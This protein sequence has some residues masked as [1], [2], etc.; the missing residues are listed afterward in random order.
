M[1]ALEAA[2]EK[3]RMEIYS[4]GE[5]NFAS[6]FLKK[7]Y[8][9]DAFK[10]WDIF[11]RNNANKFFKDRHYLHSE[12]GN[13]F[14]AA[15]PSATLT[16]SH[17]GGLMAADDDP[18]AKTGA[19]PTFVVLELGCGAGN[20]V[21]PLLEKAAADAEGPMLVHACDFSKRAVQLV[22]EHAMYDPSMVN[23]FVCDITANELT[24]NIAP[25]SVDTATM[26]FVLSAIALDKM[27][28]ALKNVTSVLKPGGHVLVRDY[29]A[30]DL[31]EERLAGKS[32]QKLDENFYVRGDGTRAFYFTEEVLSQLFAQQGFVCKQLFVHCRDVEN[33]AKELLMK[34]RWIQAVFQLGPPASAYPSTSPSQTTCS[35][36]THAPPVNGSHRVPPSEPSQDRFSS[37]EG[38]VVPVPPPLFKSDKSSLSDQSTYST[39]F[40][41][42]HSPQPRAANDI[43]AKSASHSVH[44]SRLG[45]TSAETTAVSS[46]LGGTSSETAAAP[47]GLGVISAEAFCNSESSG[48]EQQ[49]QHT[50]REVESKGVAPFKI[51][52]SE[53]L[54]DE[55]GAQRRER[56]EKQLPR[57]GHGGED[58]ELAPEAESCADLFG[59]PLDF[60]VQDVTVGNC[61][62][63]IKS[64]HKS[65]QHTQPHTGLLMWESALAL[66]GLLAPLP[67]PPSPSSSAN[68]FSGRPSG[69]I[70][71]GQRVLE[72]GCGAAALSS[73]IASRSARQIVATDGDL[74]TLALLEE[75]LRLNSRRFPVE[76]ITSRQLVW[77][78]KDVEADILRESGGRGFDVILGADVVYVKEAVPK[79]FATAR[80]LLRQH[81]DVQEWT[82][83][84]GGK[85]MR[86]PVLLLC[87]CTRRVCEADIIK[88]AEAA[89]LQL[90]KDG[91]KGVI[92]GEEVEIA[93]GHTSR[94][95]GTRGVFELDPSFGPLRLMCFTHSASE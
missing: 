17:G 51:H 65:Q 9:R 7:K 37:H 73:L 3:P 5:G 58:Q 55:S 78:D 52:E 36:S 34:R 28:A 63:R 22:K 42:H 4:S 72:L 88:A 68:P 54:R 12:W 1:A 95:R 67:L 86:M 94:G 44:L 16:Q 83:G 8:E 75:N 80:N 30:G 87:H 62:I 6:S 90:V 56:Q 29:A 39:T 66:A 10:Y 50:V 53:G 2:P 21:Y 59:E 61:S 64:L 40:A 46:G 70:L 26:V 76:R 24:D 82:G 45:G 89:G 25:C 84:M 13:Y 77:G 11:Y 14:R 49:R 43:G 15:S 23:A 93:Y 71:S 35:S 19:R 33:R 79:L 74:A 81:I 48:Q 31:A 69:S 57:R 32:K 38:A 91:L 85:S 41:P 20:T 92:G 27:P 18:T 47:C 60:V